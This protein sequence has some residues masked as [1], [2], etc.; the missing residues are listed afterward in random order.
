[1]ST[2]AL[3]S[4]EER[5]VGTSTNCSTI[6]GT[7]RRALRDTG[8]GASVAVA[9]RSR[10]CAPPP[11]PCPSSV[12]LRSGACTRTGPSQRSAARASATSAGVFPS[13]GGPRPHR[14]CVHQTWRPPETKSK[15]RLSLVCDRLNLRA[16][17]V[18]G[19]WWWWWCVCVWGG[20]G[21]EGEGEGK[22][23]GGEGGEGGGGGRGGGLVF[24]V[25]DMSKCVQYNYDSGGRVGLVMN[26]THE[27]SRQKI[28]R[29]T[30][31]PKLS[32]HI[33]SVI[34]NTETPVCPLKE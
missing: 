5:T 20:E 34:A 15:L 13:D 33:H 11:R 7:R 31:Q 8:G 4:A 9:L 28:M 30:W 25:I 22:G 6:C 21:G 19:G 16:L 1:M 23:R 2:T 3:Q 24:A 27:R 29:H 14:R 10:R 26:V 18:G 32:F 12:L 17:V